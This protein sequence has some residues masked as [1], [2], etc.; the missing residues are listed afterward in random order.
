MFGELTVYDATERFA[1]GSAAQQQKGMKAQCATGAVVPYY[2]EKHSPVHPYKG[3][4]WDEFDELGKIDD[5]G[6]S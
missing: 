2:S 6:C 3:R 5:A 4:L 1:L